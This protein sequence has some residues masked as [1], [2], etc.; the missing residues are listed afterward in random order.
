M[1]FKTVAI[2]ALVFIVVV[3]GTMY[4]LTPISISTAKDGTPAISYLKEKKAECNKCIETNS[5]LF[6]TCDLNSTE[7]V[8]REIMKTACNEKCRVLFIGWG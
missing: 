7:D 2:I 6:Q 8:C 4:L 3:V 5:P 1:T